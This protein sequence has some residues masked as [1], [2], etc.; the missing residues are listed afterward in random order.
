M[1][2]CMEKSISVINR[3]KLCNTKLNEEFVRKMLRAWETVKGL[4]KRY[5]Q[6]ER[7]NRESMV[8]GNYNKASKQTH[9]SW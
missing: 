6:L 8:D 3:C 5:M 9:T 4:Q 1:I 7:F 2:V